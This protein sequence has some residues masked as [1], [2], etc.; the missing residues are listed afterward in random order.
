MISGDGSITPPTAYTPSLSTV[1]AADQAAVKTAKTTPKVGYSGYG[2]DLYILLTNIIASD[3]SSRSAQLTLTGKSDG[4]TVLAPDTATGEMDMSQLPN[5]LLE[6]AMKDVAYTLDSNPTITIPDGG[7]FKAYQQP[8][9]ITAV[10]Y[11]DLGRGT[12]VRGLSTDPSRLNAATMGVSASYE[13]VA[14]NQWVNDGVFSYTVNFGADMAGSTGSGT[15]TGL[16]G[17]PGDAGYDWGTLTLG[18]VNG[19]TSSWIYNIGGN[20]T[21]SFGSKWSDGKLTGSGITNGLYYLGLFGPNAEEISG[22]GTVE[23][24]GKYHSF[25]AAGKKQ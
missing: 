22:G 24:D 2:R 15:I 25:G 21:S 4:T 19:A 20:K 7:T 18:S 10:T 6:Y 17:K 1:P 3:H 5:G 23:I 13:G 11:H 8:Y 16:K 14:F 9:S 12:L